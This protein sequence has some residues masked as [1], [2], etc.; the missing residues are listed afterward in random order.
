MHQT[1]PIFIIHTFLL[2]L[3]IFSSKSVIAQEVEDEREFDYSKGGE[4]GPAH[5]GDLKHDWSDCKKGA[6]QSPIDMSSDRVQVIAKSGEIKRRYKPSIAIVK[7]RG[8]DI[9]LQWLNNSAGMIKIN[10]TDYF[11]QQGHWHSPS[12]HT[13]NGRGFDLELH[14]VHVSQDPNVTYT[15]AVIAL[16][17]K[18]G[19]PDA[20]LN[21]LIKIVMPMADKLT[22]RNIGVIDPKDIKMGGRKYYRYMGSLTVPPCTQGVIWTINK[23]I[24]TVSQDQVRALRIA[25]H[26][27]AE[28]NARPLQPL[29]R[30]GVQLYDP[31][32]T[33]N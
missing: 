24:R 13:I 31:E 1:I 11:L 8:H 12:E 15:I 10:G 4:K 3:L 17:Y 28:L 29:N 33:N 2:F 25:V 19:P 7:N 16:L 18:I 6:M 27:Y 21:K 23:K 9:S 20:F 14:M 30:R 26:D 5:W 22:E 32:N